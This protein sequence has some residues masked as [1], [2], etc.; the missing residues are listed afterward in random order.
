MSRSGARDALFAYDRPGAH[1]AV[2][3]VWSQRTGSSD[4]FTQ[5]PNLSRVR[6]VVE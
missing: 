3:R 4:I 1:Y 5:V 6:V 2:V